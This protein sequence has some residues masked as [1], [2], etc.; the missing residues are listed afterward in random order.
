MNNLNY[1]ILEMKKRKKV[2][3]FLLFTLHL[4][5][6]ITNP[7]IVFRKKIEEFNQKQNYLKFYNLKLNELKETLNQ[8]FRN[9]I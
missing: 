8:V 3:M 6:N 5:I 7:L 9:S 2:L 4:L 1:L